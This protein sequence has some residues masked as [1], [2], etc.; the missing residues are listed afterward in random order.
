MSVAERAELTRR[1]E[2]ADRRQT[3]RARIVLACAEGALNADVARALDL[4]VATVATVAKWRRKF[5]AEWFDGLADAA[6]SGRPKAELVLSE[7]DRTQ[8]ISWARR[9]KTAQY[10]AM[11]ARV[12]LRAPKVGRT[13]RSRPISASTSRP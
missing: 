4:A 6:R 2:S 5:A 7:E 11:R 3:E 10:L 1:A 13:S 8:L 12:V 9:A